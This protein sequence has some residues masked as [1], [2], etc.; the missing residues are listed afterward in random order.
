MTHRWSKLLLGSEGRLTFRQTDNVVWIG[1]LTP[2]FTTS[3]SGAWSCDTTLSDVSNST[4]SAVTTVPNSVN[5]LLDIDLDELPDQP[6]IAV[7]DNDVIAH[8]SASE[9]LGATPIQSV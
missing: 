3:R 1:C 4:R 8:G 9:L 7:E 2:L 5:G 6:R